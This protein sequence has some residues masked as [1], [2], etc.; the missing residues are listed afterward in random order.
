MVILALA[1]DFSGCVKLLFLAG[2]NRQHK[3]TSRKTLV[4]LE[5]NC[6]SHTELTLYQLR[7]NKSNYNCIFCVQLSTK[8]WTLTMTTDSSIIRGHYQLSTRH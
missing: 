7:L 2:K 4:K 5:V 1:R 8:W 3:K 6:L